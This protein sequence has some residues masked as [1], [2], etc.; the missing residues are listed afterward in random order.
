[1][2]DIDE[3]T[4][5]LNPDAIPPSRQLL[6]RHET[7]AWIID[8]TTRGIPIN[9]PNAIPRTR[10]KRDNYLLFEN[11]VIARQLAAFFLLMLSFFE[12]PSYCCP[13]KACV[14]PDSGDLFLSTV[15]YFQPRRALSVNAMLL[16]ILICFFLYDKF[17]LQGI[18]LHPYPRILTVLLTALVI[19]LFWVMYHR[20]YPPFRPAPY[21]RAFLPL[22]YWTS[23]RECTMAIVAVL[24]PFLDV[25]SILTAFTLIFGWLVTLFF[26]D[27]KSADRYFG[28]LWTGMYSAFTTL[29]T[30]D[31]PMQSMALLDYSRPSALFFLIFIVIGVFLLFN[32]L[33]AVVYNAYTSHMEKLI[34][35]KL[36]ARRYAVNLAFDVLAGADG[37]VSFTDLKLLFDELRQNKIHTSLDEERVQH[38]FVALDRNSDGNISLDEFLPII[39]VLQLE[40]VIEAENI[41]LVQ[42]FFPQFYAT[43]R[44]QRVTEYVRSGTLTF[45]I[46]IIMFVNV[47]I[48]LIE[49][50]M[51]LTE[52]ETP[53]SVAFFATV[54]C[55]FSVVYIVE[56][57]LKVLSQGFDRYW[58]YFSNRFDF[59]V[60][61]LL[62]VGAI[63]VL[64]PQT[65]Y[66]R[67]VVRYL[68]LLRCLRLF[69]LLS[70]VPRF[71]RIV[72]VFS[73]LIPAS[74]PLFAF[75]F[76][77]LYVFAAAGV[78]LFGGLIYSTNPNLNPETNPLVDAYV[79]ND[80]WLLNFNDMA[81]AWYTLFSAVIVGYLTEIA[82]AIAATSAFGEYAKIF[83]IFHFVANSLIVSNVVLAFVVDLF[84]EVDEQGDKAVLDKLNERYGSGRVKVLRQRSTSDEVFSTMFEKVQNVLYRSH[85]AELRALL[86]T[87][88]S[89]QL[90]AQASG[91]METGE[92]SEGQPSEG[93]PSEGQPSEGDPADH[94][95]HF[96]ETE[97]NSA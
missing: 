84:V 70:D 59:Y 93:Q 14:A 19:D 87:H 43:P 92:P 15:P 52:D 77:T 60:T 18:H 33:L 81:S 74:G 21:L 5:L 42:R 3:E 40:F 10:E 71:Q 58:K 27:V 78:E 57:I 63:Y 25:F 29:T 16:T 90:E 97:E 41:S 12:I 26:H 4:P 73:I 1:M 6:S 88:E 79:S 24:V 66:D 2:D 54:E 75:F 30:A 82:E 49:T 7:A 36:N 31:W 38:V 51:D 95:V 20:G 23:L 47:I 68:V 56:M 62:L 76:L 83:F 34:I 80:Y 61:W 86:E 91:G 46:G 9:N 39:D 67:E 64:I 11:T 37:N 65:T 17:N 22:F 48:V 85:T 96:K 28:N 53:A 94:R 55:I 32:V 69:A 89:Q 35:E 44:W 50:T 45:H 13:S 72:R 8:E